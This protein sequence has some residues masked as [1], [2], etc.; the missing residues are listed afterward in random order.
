MPVGVLGGGMSTLWALRT[1][2][3]K[4][5]LIG[6]NL[7]GLHLSKTVPIGADLRGANLEER[8]SCRIRAIGQFP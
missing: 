3:S 8:R 1:D 4:A 5:N 6:A 7:N 2:L